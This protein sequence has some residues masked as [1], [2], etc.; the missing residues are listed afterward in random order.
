V[1]GN[2]LIERMPIAE[3]PLLFARTNVPPAERVMRPDAT[4]AEVA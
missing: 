4:V 2:D 3:S 1:R